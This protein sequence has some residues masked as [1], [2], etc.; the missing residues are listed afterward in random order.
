MAFDQESDECVTH[1]PSLY[2][3]D[4]NGYILCVS[5]CPGGLDR[6]LDGAF[7]MRCVSQCPPGT[8]GS[9]GEQLKRCVD[10][11]SAVKAHTAAAGTLLA[12]SLVLLIVCI[13]AL[14]YSQWKPKLVQCI[15]YLKKRMA[16]SKAC[17]K[18]KQDS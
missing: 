6:V 10:D 7:G 11:M 18:Q 12:L 4:E 16:A 3:V 5:E 13:F 14:T 9:E 2:Y 15:G 8:K 17:S 1:C